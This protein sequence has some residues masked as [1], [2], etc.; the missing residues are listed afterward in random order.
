VVSKLTLVVMAAGIGSRYGG[1]KQIDPVGPHGELVI[2]YSI[3]D[4][5]RAGFDKI[6]F[7]IRR[8]IEEAFRKKVG[9][10]I[11]AQVE[12]AYVFQDLTLVPQGFV[13]PAERKKPWGTGQAI[14]LCKDEVKTP[15]VALNA[16]DFYGPTAYQTLAQYLSRVRDHKGAQNYCMIGYTLRN[17][18]SEHG[19]VARGICEATPDGFLAD[20][21]ERTRIEQFPDGIKYTEDGKDWITLSADTL[22]SMNIWGF[23]WS[24][25]SELEIRFP[26]FLEQNAANI[27]KAEF[28]I[29]EVV[30]S[31]VREKKAR[32]KILPTKEKWFGVTYPEDRP[33]VQAVIRGLIQKGLYPESL[34]SETE[35]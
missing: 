1:L 4:A 5:L 18:L 21:R 32:V 28:F 27:L 10:T 25:F 16:D 26:R 11:E 34:W 33:W 24:I 6:V 3:Y 23:A 2:D 22:V 29:P 8:D 15:F 13:V 30:G 19:H 12:T 31:L 14:L 9:K 7:V 35:R 20:I 17:T